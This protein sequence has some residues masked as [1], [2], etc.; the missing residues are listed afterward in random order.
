M[1]KNLGPIERALR[2]LLGAMAIMVVLSQ[3]QLGISEMIIG[4]AGVFLVLNGVLA[5]CY[6]WRWLGINTAIDKSCDLERRSD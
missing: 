3:P 1:R 2:L 4:V 5:R 6:L